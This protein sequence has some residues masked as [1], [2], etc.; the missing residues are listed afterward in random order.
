MTRY[1]TSVALLS[2]FL[3]AAPAKAEFVYTHHFTEDSWNAGIQQFMEWRTE[4]GAV[5]A[6]NAQVEVLVSLQKGGAIT[7]LLTIFS[8]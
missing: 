8:S 2:A 3:I 5:Y 1:I 4:Q 7:A 6:E